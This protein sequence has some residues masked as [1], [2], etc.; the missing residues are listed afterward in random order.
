MM[1][2]V[3]ESCKCQCV[4]GVAVKSS[5]D[6]RHRFLLLAKARETVIFVQVAAT[7]PLGDDYL[8]VF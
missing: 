6:V 2:D 7:G 8:Q 4:P 5:L 1:A 3:S